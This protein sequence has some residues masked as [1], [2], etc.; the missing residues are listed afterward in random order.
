MKL[1]PKARPVRIKL[2][3]GGEEHSSLDSLRANFNVEEVL[4]LYESGG[5][6]NWL[7]QIN[8]LDILDQMNKIHAADSEIKK[9]Q[10]CIM[11]FF[12]YPNIEEHLK[13]DTEIDNIWSIEGILMKW[14][15][16]YP[17]SFKFLLSSIISIPSNKEEMED[18]S[19]EGEKKM[20]P[21]IYYHISVKTAR[22]INEKA[23]RC[24]DSL[25]QRMLGKY[26]FGIIKP[27]LEG[28][29]IIRSLSHKAYNLDSG[30]SIRPN[31]SHRWQIEYR[32]ERLLEQLKDEWGIC[33]DK[34]LD[35]S[36]DIAK[37]LYP[38]V[39][40]NFVSDF[41]DILNK[42]VEQ[43]SE[44]S[45]KAQDSFSTHE[46]E[47]LK[48]AIEFILSATKDIKIGNIES[49]DFGLPLLE[50]KSSKKA[51]TI[52]RNWYD[53]PYMIECFD[54]TCKLSRLIE[55]WSKLCVYLYLYKYLFGFNEMSFDWKKIRFDYAINFLYQNKGKTG[56]YLAYKSVSNRCNKDTIESV[57][58]VRRKI[59]QAAL[60]MAILSNEESNYMTNKIFE[61]HEIGYR[62]ASLMLGLT[63]P[64]N[65]MERIFMNLTY[66]ERIPFIAEH[67]L[68]F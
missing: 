68:D 47:E 45:D 7:R 22:A 1:Y 57:S 63:Q 15:D 20:I 35:S 3:V 25:T 56:L 54:S 32:Q 23:I 52:V 46:K 55:N 2:N 14:Y 37:L 65:E 48:K 13:Y 67:I 34:V 39:G 62:P 44:D 66:L 41:R 29:R 5:L 49:K 33:S 50:L 8:R 58:G 24:K 21:L 61:L 12:D 31:D 6:Q 60:L 36:A 43:I 51:L 26:L 27:S 42:M 64:K 30:V 59:F 16:T 17:S 38:L 9:F 40:I 53:L 11:I 28:I 10:K 19:F 4:K 18:G